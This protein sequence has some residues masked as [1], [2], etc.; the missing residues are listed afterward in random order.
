MLREAGSEVD[1]E[2]IL[3]ACREVLPFTKAPKVVV[4]GE[5]LP[6]TATGKYQRTRLRPLFAEW[7]ATQFRPPGGRR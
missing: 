3:A 1:A 6:V 2:T 4:F 5:D 7:K